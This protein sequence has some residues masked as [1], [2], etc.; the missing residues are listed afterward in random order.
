MYVGITYEACSE[1]RMC[2][3]E[4]NRNYPDDDVIRESSFT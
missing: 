1:R 2:V 4:C 3:F